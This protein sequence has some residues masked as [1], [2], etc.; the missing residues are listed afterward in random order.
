MASTRSGFGSCPFLLLSVR[1]TSYTRHSGRGGE[2]S[3]SEIARISLRTSQVCTWT[4]TG[5]LNDSWCHMQPTE[6]RFSRLNSVSISYMIQYIIQRDCRSVQCSPRPGGRAIRQG[7]S[8]LV[9]GKQIF[10]P[11][12]RAHSAR[13]RSEQCDKSRASRKQ[14]F[15]TSGTKRP[16]IVSRQR[17]PGRTKYC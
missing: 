3:A 15:R 16:W 1:Q 13:H 11:G 12:M 17:H 6:L 14:E 10:W 8:V 5:C 9:Y 7:V 2:N 4:C